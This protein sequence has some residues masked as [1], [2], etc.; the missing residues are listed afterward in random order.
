M[1]CLQREAMLLSYHWLLYQFQ[2]PRSSKGYHHLV[3]CLPFLLPPPPPA[4]SLLA[5]LEKFSSTW[6][7]CGSNFPEQVY[8]RMSDG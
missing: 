1:P 8:H 5:S 7:D 2:D 3:L 4:V 6:G